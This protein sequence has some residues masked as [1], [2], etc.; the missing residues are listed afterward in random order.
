MRNPVALVILASI[1]NYM[2]LEACWPE[3]HLTQGLFVALRSKLHSSVWG[4]GRRV[5]GATKPADI[6][7]E[8]IRTLQAT[9]QLGS[10]AR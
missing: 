3:F 4:S 5:E 2:K 1:L 6:V 9:L 8:K 10:R 7:W